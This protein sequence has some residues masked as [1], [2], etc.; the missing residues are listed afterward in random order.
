MGG[1]RSGPPIL[2]YLYFK[3]WLTT[4]RNYGACKNKRRLR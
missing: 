2:E 3:A 4:L 1:P